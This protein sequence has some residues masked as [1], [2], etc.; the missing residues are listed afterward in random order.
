LSDSGVSHELVLVANYNLGEDDPTPQV[1]QEWARKHRNARTVIRPKQGAMGWDM[2]TGL[3]AAAGRTLIVIDGD[4]QN[5]VGD[6]FRMYQ[7]MQ[8]TG[9][10]V[11]KGRRVT[12]DDGLYRR[13]ISTVYN[14]L[15]RILFGT[16]GLWDINGK[17]KGLTREAYER[18]DLRSDDWFIDAEIVLEAHRHGLRIGELPVSFRK[19]EARASFVKPS[20]IIEFLRNMA[21]YRLTRRS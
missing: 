6:V 11:Y 16:G 2:R 8:R 4:Y 17:P 3:E 7:E 1:V 9:A 15:F 19:N 18:I 21:R 10:D 12:R 13:S 14:L 5:P 20:A